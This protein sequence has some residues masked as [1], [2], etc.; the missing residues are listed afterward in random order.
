M[1]WAEFDTLFGGTGRVIDWPSAGFRPDLP[2]LDCGSGTGVGTVALAGAFPASKIMAV[3]PDAAMRA[4]LMYRVA[5]TPG[6]LERVTVLP[7]TLENVNLPELL[8]GVVA[9]GFLYFLSPEQR[10]YAWTLFAQH[11]VPDA[12]VVFEDGE[13]ANPTADEPERLLATR[14]MGTLRYERW[15]A[16][17]PENGAVRFTNTVRVWDGESQLNEDTSS[18]RSWPLTASVTTRE[19]QSTGCFTVE[20]LNP[21][22][23]I[24]RRI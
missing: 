6:L 19:C 10:E 13:A 22:H 14:H 9:T 16:Q 12:G 1:A 8:G 21:G 18:W 15:F 17:R 2:L 4:L 7:T 5:S 11:V 24:A 3:E 23:L 20:P